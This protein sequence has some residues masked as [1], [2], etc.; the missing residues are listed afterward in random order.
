MRRLPVLLSV[1]A[2][3]VAA[4]GLALAQTPPPAAVSTHGVPV[5]ETQ[6]WLTGLGGRVGAPRTVEGVTSL[7]VADQPLPWNLTFYACGPSLCDDIQYSAAFSGPITVDQINAWN[8]ENRFLKAFFV[9]ATAGGEA[10]AVVQYDVILTG[11][12]TDQLREPTVIWIQ[13]L[14]TFAEGLAAAAA[15]AAP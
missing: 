1:L 8:R 14:R 10:G 2:L 11:T 15:P 7:H 12:G 13:M 6:A 9:P 4:P 3:A 5:A